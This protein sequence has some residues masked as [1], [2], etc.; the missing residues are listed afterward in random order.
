MVKTTGPSAGMAHWQSPAL[1]AADKPKK[2]KSVKSHL[3]HRPELTRKVMTQLWKEYS[4]TGKSKR[5]L[6]KAVAK[7]LSEDALKD[8]TDPVQAVQRHI[9]RLCKTGVN[10]DEAR[11]GRPPK[12]TQAQT[13]QALKAFKGGYKIPDEQGGEGTWFGFGSW[14]HALMEDSGNSDKLRRILAESG[15]SAR[16]MWDALKTA[17]GGGFHKIH[18]RY[19]YKMS[20]TLRKE[21]LKKAKEWEKLTEEELL[22]IVWIDEK[23]EWVHGNRTYICYADDDAKHIVRQGIMR[24]GEKKKMRWVSACNARLGPIYFEP[25]SGSDSYE[26]PFEVRTCA[27]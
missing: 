13:T 12:M 10:G 21:R 26:T 23:T 2:K 7:A 4:K 8:I 1:P 14:E 25:I 22:N 9:D 11:S 5:S 27:P 19:T 20:E 6:Y 16:S 3:P 18:I 15:M 17:N 24:F